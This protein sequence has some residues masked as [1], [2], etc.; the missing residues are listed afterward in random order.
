MIS[1][2]RGWI[3]I[4][5]KKSLQECLERF[6][7]YEHSNFILNYREHDLSISNLGFNFIQKLESKA[8][9]N[10]LYTNCEINR[11]IKPT[12]HKTFLLKKTLT[13]LQVVSAL[14]YN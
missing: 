1:Q 2:L 13:F 6:E 3:R 10:Y 12:N 9:K 8:L 7:K 14:L 5:Y 11:K 4:L